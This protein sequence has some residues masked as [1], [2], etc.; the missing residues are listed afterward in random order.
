ME[1]PK[2]PAYNEASEQCRIMREY[3]EPPNENKFF[4]VG[5]IEGMR[6]MELPLADGKDEKQAKNWI[7]K[8]A[9]ICRDDGGATRE[10]GSASVGD[11]ANKRL[12]V[13]EYKKTNQ[14]KV[15]YNSISYFFI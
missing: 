9:G 14:G 11:P 3:F 1:P 8:F 12:Q 7:K 6:V 2:P 10:L 4:Y 15:S 13:Q 5:S